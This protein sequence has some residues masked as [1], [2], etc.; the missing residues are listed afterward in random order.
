[1]DTLGEGGGFESVAIAVDGHGIA[2]VA[3]TRPG[4]GSP[5]GFLR[6]TAFPG[7]TVFDSPAGS[8]LS[9]PFF[10]RGTVDEGSVAQVRVDSGDWVNVTG[11]PSWETR[12]DTAT[13]PTGPHTITVR[14][15]RATFDECSAPQEF[16]FRTAS[17]PVVA[18]LLGVAIALV[19]ILVVVAFWHSRRARR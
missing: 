5:R 10:V 6:R 3:W 14:A 15:C 8:V 19:I 18:T 4:E 12:I 7:V 9:E 11:S 2:F 17:T 1:V 16:A 13:L